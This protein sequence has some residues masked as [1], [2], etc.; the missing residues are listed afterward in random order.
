MLQENPSP[1]ASRQKEGNV[2]QAKAGGGAFPFPC[3]ASTAKP[4]HGQLLPQGLHLGAAAAPASCGVLMGCSWRRAEGCSRGAHGTAVG[5]SWDDRGTEL[6]DAHGTAVGCSWGAHG[7]AMGCSGHPAMGCSQDTG[8]TELW[9]ARGALVAQPWRTPDTQLT[10]QAH[11]LPSPQNRHRMQ[12]QLPS[13]PPQSQI[14]P[15]GGPPQRALAT[16]PQHASP[17]QPLCR[18]GSRAAL[19][20]ALPRPRRGGVLGAASF[21]AGSAGPH[22]RC[23]LRPAGT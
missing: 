15:W 9:D 14:K 3:T 17:V 1:R 8:G 11:P 6:W 22:Q 10:P 21:P 7:T 18:R 12:P 2:S 4:H 20:L 16:P 13:L 23:W 5:C 19:C